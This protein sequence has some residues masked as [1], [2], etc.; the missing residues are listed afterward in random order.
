MAE[1][2]EFYLLI[3]IDTYAGNV[4]R[5]LVS[6]AFGA[7]MEHAWDDE[8]RDWEYSSN[9]SPKT[10]ELEADPEL[11]EMIN[12]WREA[13]IYHYGEYGDTPQEIENREIGSGKWSIRVELGLE[14]VNELLERKHWDFLKRRLDEA[15]EAMGFRIE[16]L[17]QRVKTIS[18][19]EGE[20]CLA[21]SCS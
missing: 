18:V 10:E 12:M 15:A 19:V 3:D 14:F 21:S 7:V 8:R 11:D 5:Q 6:Y 13:V 9:M 2:K 20:L 16:G 17:R 1:Y 4:E